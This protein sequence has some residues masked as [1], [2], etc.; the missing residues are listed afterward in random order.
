MAIKQTPELDNMLQV[1][2]D[3]GAGTGAGRV[4]PRRK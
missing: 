3:L 1:A 4:D 2:A